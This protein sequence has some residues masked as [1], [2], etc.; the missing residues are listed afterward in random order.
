MIY[1]P[2][3]RLDRKIAK[4]LCGLSPG[5]VIAFF[6]HLKVLAGSANMTGYSTRTWFCRSFT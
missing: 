2:E 5:S 4:D 3:V 1:I 6:R